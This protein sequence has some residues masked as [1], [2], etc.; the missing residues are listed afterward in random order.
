[1]CLNKKNYG[2]SCYLFASRITYER[3]VIE[4]EIENNHCDPFTKKPI[5]KADLIPND[6]LKKSILEYNF[7]SV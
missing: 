6:F 5:T 2:R 7:M 1:M 4:A 3:S